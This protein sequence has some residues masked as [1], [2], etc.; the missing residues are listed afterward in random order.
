MNNICLS[1]FDHINDLKCYFLADDD[2]IP[3]SASAQSLGVRAQKK[4][5][6]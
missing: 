1:F 4:L 3:A 6:R 5:L 2:E